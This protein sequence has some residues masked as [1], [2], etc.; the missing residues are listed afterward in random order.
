M[1]TIVTSLTA[2]SITVIWDRKTVFDVE[3][4]YVESWLDQWEIDLH[5]DDVLAANRDRLANVLTQSA[6]SFAVEIHRDD[7]AFSEVAD[8]APFG[9]FGVRFRAHWAPATYEVELRGG[10]KDGTVFTWRRLRKPLVFAV[11]REVM[12][13]PRDAGL[14]VLLPRT[15]TYDFA[16]WSETERRWVY[17][18]E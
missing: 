2:E 12:L 18:L 15:I 7:V 16:G 9:A 17:D 13:T 4:L 11:A 6:H 1:P 3:R 14:S 10:E 8:L 5:G